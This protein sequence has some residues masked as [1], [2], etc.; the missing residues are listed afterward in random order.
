MPTRYDEDGARAAEPFGIVVVRNATGTPEAGRDGPADPRPTPIASDSRVARGIRT[1]G[2][3]EGV[4]PDPASVAVPTGCGP[5][6]Q[7]GRP[8]PP[9][10]S[11][12]LISL[13]KTGAR[14]GFQFIP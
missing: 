1:D 8:K 5:N 7:T 10:T 2:R 12:Y 6:G 4:I 9:P 14:K 13:R 11:K 3:V